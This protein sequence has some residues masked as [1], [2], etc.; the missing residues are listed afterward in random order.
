MALSEK[1]LENIILDWLNTMRNCFAFKINT[2][3]VYD[4]RKKVFRKNNGKHIHRG[5]CDILGEYDGKFFGIEVKAGYNKPSDDQIIFMNLIKRGG[6]VAF[7]TNDF[8]KC[9]EAF[10]VHFPESVFNE[11]L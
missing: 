8:D 11:I 2:T 6:G 3:G 10:A 7:W 1:Q 5:T 9:K 4:P